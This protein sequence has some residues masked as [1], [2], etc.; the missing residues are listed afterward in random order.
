LTTS[1]IGYR[2]TA[3]WKLGVTPHQLVS[4]DAVHLRLSPCNKPSDDGGRNI[5]VSG[6]LYVCK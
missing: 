2:I 1:D 6:K 5:L 4:L 3:F